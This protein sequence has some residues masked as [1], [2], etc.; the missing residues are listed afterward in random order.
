[1]NDV[2]PRFSESLEDYLEAIE[3]LGGKNVRSVDIATKLGV[4]KA[5]VNRAVNTL[6][7]NGLVVKAPY[8]DISLTDMGIE[9]SE[10][11]LRKHLVIKRLLVEV[12]G[13]EERIAENE[14]CG[15][16]HNISDDTL[17]R[18]EKLLLE[19]TTR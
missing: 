2:C 8:G 12:L 6:M 3:M 5:S 19:K 15:I 11:V 17:S 13:V 9:T 4:S 10:K 7:Q 14:A 18:F 1:M 16:E